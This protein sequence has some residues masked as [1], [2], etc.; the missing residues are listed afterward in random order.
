MKQKIIISSITALI[1]L[2]LGYFIFSGST[3]DDGTATKATEESVQI[4]TCSMHPQVRQPDPGDCPICGMDLIPAGEGGND[5]PLVFE[6]SKDAMK[7]ANIQTSI[8][9][10]SGA[11]KAE[12]TLSGRIKADETTASSIVTHIPGR[13]EKLYVSYTGE[14]VSKGQKIASIYSPKLITAQRELLEAYKLMASNPNLLEASKNKLRYWKISNKEINEIIKSGHVKEYFDIRA[15]HTGVIQNK[16]VTVGDYLMQGSV[17]FEIQNLNSL[18]AVF[19]VYE[20]NLKSVGLGKEISFTTSSLAGETFTG[21]ISFVD[22]T[23]NPMTRTAAVRLQI[24]NAKKQLKPEMFIIGK[25]KT[26]SS[27]Q[28]DVQLTVPKTAVLWTGERSVV[29]VKQADID[30]PS[31]EFREVIIG[32]PIGTEY[33]VLEGLVAG[34]EVVTNGAFIIDAS[35]QLNNQMS[36]MNRSLIVEKK[37]TIVAVEDYSE[38]TPAK[39]KSQLGRAINS[40]FEI[41]NALAE[42]NVKLAQLKGDELLKNLD[43]I[44]MSL[45]KSDAHIFWMSLNTSVKKSNNEIISASSIE[46]ARISFDDLSIDMIKAVKAFGLNEGTHYVHFCPMAFDDTGAFWLSKTPTVKNPYFGSQMLKCGV[47]KDTIK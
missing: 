37:K 16:K 38:Q 22:P 23:I 28:T 40:Y 45:V 21:K 32:D 2:A 35:A 17:L 6:M 26:T 33:L 4:W 25:L 3:S 46:E 14:N 42:D 12:L 39:F 18:W 11:N 29:Y 19:D 30:V 15:D 1:G 5:N 10:G 41:K 13:I 7:I 27:A 20:S 43:L 36:M 47:I 8:I 9:G 44:D 31:F 34:E 24:N